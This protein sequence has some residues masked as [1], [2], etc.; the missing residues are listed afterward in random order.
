MPA[1]PLARA[2]AALSRGDVLIA[3][4]EALTALQARPEDIE[5]R[6]LAALA[7][8]RA[9]AAE[10]ARDAVTQ[11]MRCFKDGDRLPTR[12]REDV[13]AL[14]ARLAKD[15]ALAISG[16]EQR[17]RLE[18]AA[19][20]YEAVAKRYGGYYSYINAATLRLLFGDTLGARRL[21]EQAR[22]LVAADNDD[23][24]GS[25][26]RCA[27]QAEAA[28]ILGDD[29]GARDAIVRAAD[30]S[31]RDFAARAVSY[32]QLRLVCAAAATDRGILAP[33]APPS[34]LH[35]CGHRID[36][37]GAPGRFPATLE[38][39]V[40][41]QVRDYLGHRDV[42]FGYGSLASGADI[43]VA[44]GLLSA[45]AE[46]HVVLPFGRDEFER[47]SVAPGGSAWSSRFAVCLDRAASVTY[48]S[49][50]AYLGHDELLGYAA[51]IAMGHALN[52]AQFLDAEVEQLAV[53]D[54]APAAGVAGTAHDVQVWRDTGRSAH[55]IPLPSRAQSTAPASPREP[56]GGRQVRA[57]I[58][59]DLHGFSRLR[60][61]HFPVF[62]DQVIG[63]L[64]RVL[65]TH[66]HAI[67]SRNSWGDAVAAVCADVVV[68]AECALG[69]Q[70]ALAALDLTA[71][72]LPHDLGL[73]IGA[74]AG[75]VM[76]I[77]DPIRRELTYWGRELTRAASIEPRT[78]EG[79]VYVTDAF[80][81]LLA[82]E[83]S[84]PFITE[85]VGRVTTAKDFET[86]PM[87]RLRRKRGRI[88]PTTDAPAAS[89][90]V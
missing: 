88:E 49:D 84:A 47:T 24:A 22:M 35:Y 85:Y 63:L 58:F 62:V 29:R 54:G 76:P 17:G 55:V 90:R 81:A 10:R 9:G 19:E 46:L 86:I 65:N 50:S 33:L 73:R 6:F 66:S 8:A 56:S 32:R 89:R 44:E 77:V 31:G 64:G 75:P 70:D 69:F 41:E 72:G 53:W 13:E 3:Y 60:D 57:I 34:V 71:I 78:P 82:L 18:R 40:A 15:D 83:R 74:H 39:Q 25:Y 14:V 11:L 42:G 21:A 37:S 45:G 38:R 23:T 36:G 26:W 20:L 28:L 67:L 80:A 52:R 2:R 16:S 30:A 61:E 51:R 59:T 27:T 68:A 7:L 5:A 43:L 12:L 4:D 79:E 87:Y 48:A 1:D